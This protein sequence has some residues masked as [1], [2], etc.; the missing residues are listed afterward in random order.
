MKKY[1]RVQNRVH[2]ATAWSAAP[3]ATQQMTNDVTFLVS[4]V[5][6]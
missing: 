3:W 1:V 6:Y 4:D 2:W 5:L